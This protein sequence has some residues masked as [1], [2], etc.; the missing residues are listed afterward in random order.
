MFKINSDLEILLEEQ[1]DKSGDDI[2]SMAKF[3][4]RL[5]LSNI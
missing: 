1:I 5:E 4:C 3:K 2:G